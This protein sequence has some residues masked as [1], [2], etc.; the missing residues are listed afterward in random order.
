M[1]LS[2]L[3][4]MAA[5]LF[6]TCL[7][8]AVST[9]AET[10]IE[11]AAATAAA[12]AGTSAPSA[13]AP[14]P[15]VSIGWQLLAYSILTAAEILVSITC[16][17]FS[18]TQAPPALKSWVMAVYLCSVSAGNLLTAIVNAAWPA[19]AT[20]VQYYAF[21]TLLMLAASL[22]FLPVCCLYQEQ[23]YLPRPTASPDT[24][25]NSSPEAAESDRRAKEERERLHL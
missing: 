15:S 11:E 3:R 12:P 6:L 17:E 16:L 19:D 21:F 23:S 4:K 25:G 1:R 8:F 13:P 14:P 20:D 9:L 2:P 5:G 24:P 10:W 18:Y 22:A 7:A